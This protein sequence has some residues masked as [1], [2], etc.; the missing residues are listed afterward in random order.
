V[1][2]AAV[3]PWLSLTSWKWEI[4]MSRFLLHCG[5]IVGVFAG[6]AAVCLPAV[7]RGQHAGGA[8]KAPS[9]ELQKFR[10]DFIKKF[11]RMPLNTTLGDATFLRIMVESSNAKRGI[12]VGTATGYGAMHMGLGFERTGGHLTTIDINPEM[13]KAARENLAKMQLQDRVTV[14]EGDALEVLPQL[15]GEFDFL[16]IDAVKRDYF[17]YFK[18]VESKLKPGSVIVGDNAI[19]SANAMRDFLEFMERDPNYLI[20][21]IKASDEKKDGLAVI[22]KHK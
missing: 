11:K 2:G 1:V 12:E 17:R 8:A 9:P 20:V 10:A 14:V 3:D 4:A 21:I 7:S 19:R 13:V 22:Y 15:E 18:A 16:F 5:A 6:A